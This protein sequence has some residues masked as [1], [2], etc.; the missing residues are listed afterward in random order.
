LANKDGFIEELLR[1]ISA[2][3]HC[4]HDKVAVL[5]GIYKNVGLGTQ[6]HHPVAPWT[7]DLAFD[8]FRW[9]F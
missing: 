4:M 7:L 1:N 6:N 3:S 8:Y 5:A 9:F 2:F